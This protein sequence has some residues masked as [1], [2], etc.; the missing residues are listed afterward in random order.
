M[1]SL[2]VLI[3]ISASGCTTAIS[4][5][6]KL[7]GSAVDHED[8]KKHQQ[9]LIG[10]D[11]SAADAEFGE[12]MNAYRDVNS[13]HEYIVYPAKLDVM[14][15]YRYVVEV[16]DGKIIVL[17]KVKKYADPKT[18][19]IKGAIY[20]SKCEGK[21]PEECEK[22][23]ELGKPLLSVRNIKSNNLVQLY[24]ADL[25]E[26]DGVT[27]PHYCVLKFDASDRCEDVDVVEAAA[28]TE[29]EPMDS[30]S[31]QKKEKATG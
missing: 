6:V 18:D 12:P 10:K 13:D 4:T 31:D 14:N 9:N 23:L 26:V 15:S 24:D 3:T 16:A 1:L 25:I 21:S 8:V 19:L 30:A 17:S 2:T 7:V 29:K 11:A 22:A 28:S 20:E 27:K 5:G